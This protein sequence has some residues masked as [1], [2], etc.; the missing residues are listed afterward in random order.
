MRRKKSK[1]PAGRESFHQTTQ[2][3]KNRHTPKKRASKQER[4]KEKKKKRPANAL[5]RHV[6]HI[7]KA[8]YQ[9]KTQE[10]GDK[11]QEMLPLRGPLDKM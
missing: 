7:I 3:K 10:T 8:M 1:S 9:Q 4:E 11:R 2:K 6:H 5:A